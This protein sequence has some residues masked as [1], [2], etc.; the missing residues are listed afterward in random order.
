MEKYSEQAATLVEAI[1]RFNGD[2]EALFNFEC[3]LSMHFETW[4][5]KFANS[6][7]GIAYEF[8]CFSKMFD[9]V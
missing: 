5:Q 2:E 7:E 6:P 8:R 1:R 9:G 3:Y 4:L